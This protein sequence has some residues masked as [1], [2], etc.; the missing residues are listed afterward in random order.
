VRALATD[1]T[2]IAK[3]ATKPDPAA[4][5]AL[6]TEIGIVV[7][8]GSITPAEA[9]ILKK[10]VTNVLVSANIP[11]ALAQQTASD[12]LVVIDASGLSKADVRTIAGDV[13]AIVSDLG[14]LKP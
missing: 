1:L 9:L 10:D 5:D 2:A 11:L 3:V 12:L 13:K 7:A 4:V 14:S 6:R 8:Q